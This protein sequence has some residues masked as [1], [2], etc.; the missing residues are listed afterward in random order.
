MSDETL[1]NLSHEERRFEPAD[2]LREAGQPHRGRLR[3]GREGPAGASGRSRPSGSTGTPSG[4]R[5]STGTTRR[6]PSGSSAARSTP[7]YN[8]VDR[9]VENGAGDKVAFHWVGEPE[10]D[11]RDITYAELKDEVCKA[12]NALVELGVE[13]RR[14]RRDLHADDPRDGRSRCWRARA[15]APRTPS[16]SVAS[17]PTRCANRVED[18]DAQVVITAD[19]GYRRGA[20]S[21]LKPAVDEACEKCRATCA[22]C[23]SS[24]VRARTWSGT[25]TATSGGT[26]SSTRQ[27]A[28]HE[29]EFF[30]AEHPLYVMY[31][32][33]TTGK[34]KGI[35]HT[36][37]GYLVGCAYTHWGDLRP[38]ARR[39]R[40]LV[41]RRRRLGDRPLLRRLRAA[42]Q[43]G[44]RR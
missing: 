16:C 23:W 43:P 35:L 19:G 9:H 42:R 29:C 17:P 5:C 27:S 11:T 33:G 38:Q 13:D 24:V 4:T 28:E 20:P 12:A 25:T 40:L 14:P 22:R 26:S 32:S 18:C 37:G 2:G 44:A 39:R 34:P 21:A 41:H 36:T 10:D 3:R 7:R 1:A 30:D 15:S 31:T 6:S 8:C